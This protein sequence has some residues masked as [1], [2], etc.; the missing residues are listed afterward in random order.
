MAVVGCVHGD[1]EKVYESIEHVQKIHG[2]QIDLVLCCGDFQSLRNEY[3][4]D[5]LACPDH[6]K[7]MGT[8]WKYYSG[9]KMAPFPTLFVGGNHEASNQLHGLPYGGW[10]APNIFYLG[11]SGVVRF[12][13]L[14]IGGVSGIY[15]AHDFEKGRFEE[16]PFTSSTM[17]SCYHMR[18]FDTFQIGLLGR[19][20]E[21]GQ[22]L[23]HN[24]DVML[25]HDWP[26]GISSCGDT[27]RLL[28]FK[29]SNIEMVREIRQN[30]LGNPAT[31]ELMKILRPR[32]WFGAHLHVKFAAIFRH[33]DQ[34]FTKFLSLDKPSPGR[35]FLQV[36]DIP[37]TEPGP[38]RFEY[39]VEWL[40]ILKEV[41]QY[42]RYDGFNLF[43]P[44]AAPVR[45]AAAAR[46]DWV[47]QRLKDTFADRSQFVPSS[48]CPDDD[49]KAW[50]LNFV[51][52]VAPYTGSLPSQHEHLPLFTHQLEPQFQLLADLLQLS[53]LRPVASSSSSNPPELAGPAD[54]DVQ[55]Q[56]SLSTADAQVSDD[57]AA[58]ADN[59]EDPT[60]AEDER[61]KRLRSD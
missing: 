35:D 40:A 25:T 39:D 19:K 22:Q 36:L 20:E 26:L 1:L 16:P 55:V 57:I 11:Y 54:N 52:S 44:D 12:G 10:V 8:F 61:R 28:R 7:A 6:Y 43:L 58:V 15:K 45:A 41:C 38:K 14:R 33:D 27:E 3:D 51:Q 48:D 18:S 46:V 9:Q 53:N 17:R 5:Q 21:Y 47:A 50:P 49:W 59:S 56:D 31:A 60:E 23:Q 32:F 24:L 13:G 42:Q 2:D 34:T 37:V 30:E 4:M 29:R